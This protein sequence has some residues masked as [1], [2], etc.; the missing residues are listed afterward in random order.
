MLTG[1]IF[2]TDD[3]VD[4]PDQLAATLPFGGATLIEFQARLLI[5]AGAGHLLVVVTRLTPELLG[6]IN[7]LARRGM[8]VDPVRSARE[9]AEKIHPLAH[10]LVL[11]DGL[12]T[13][14]AVIAP[15]AME[16]EDALLVTDDA[17][18]LPGLERVGANAI[19]A[20]VARVG[21]ARIAEV[22]ALPGDYDFGSALLRVTAQSGAAQVALPPDAVAAGHGVEHDSRKL[23]ARNEALV[24]A[25]VSGRAAWIDRYVQGPVARR[26]LPVL[27]ARGW[28]AL[29]VSGGAAALMA[30]GLI[31]L[32]A[33]WSG[34]GM[35]LVV[36]ANFGLM[37]A[38]VLAWM[39]DEMDQARLSSAALLG[40]A[41]AA[42]LLLGRGLSAGAGT[43]SAMILA[44][45][46]VILAGLTERA[47]ESR[48]R[49]SWWGAPAAYPL[50]LIPFIWAGQGVIGLGMG[51]VYAALSLG[52]AIEA[53]RRQA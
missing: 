48:P 14:D 30:A 41:A 6:A 43:A 15:L 35:P 27:I 40:G 3:A 10:L 36:F 18:A 29:A 19:W 12:V 24:S 13:T 17:T 47:A 20:G 8:A 26:L 49:R 51:A 22:A 44:L 21:V 7:R 16:G 23:A 11:A 31:L 2:A 45:A 1:L 39:R 34:I 46:L 53:L 9:A 5:A 42:I 52:A 50:L 33:R 4:R 38:G 25:H 37:L 32:A 28:S